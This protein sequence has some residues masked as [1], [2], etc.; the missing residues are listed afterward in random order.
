MAAGSAKSKRTLA[1][2]AWDSVRLERQMIV[3][4]KR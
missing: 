3:K 2:S 1:V 4:V